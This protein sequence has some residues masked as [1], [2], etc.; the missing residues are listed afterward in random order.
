MLVLTITMPDGAQYDVP[1]E[2]VAKHRANYYAR[3]AEKR[4]ENSKLV[5]RNVYEGSLKNPALLKDWAQ[6]NMD[7][8][9]VAPIA[10]QIR[11]PQPV[12]YQIGWV[13]GALAV[14]NRV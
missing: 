5:Q 4:G 14:A 3:R 6:N 1:A 8:D 10:N 7:W 12:D 11:P 2:H 9:D 13:K